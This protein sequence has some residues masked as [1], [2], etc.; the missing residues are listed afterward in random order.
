LEGSTALETILA[1]NPVAVLRI[2]ENA[3]SGVP[4]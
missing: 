1:N 3:L 2:L 4:V